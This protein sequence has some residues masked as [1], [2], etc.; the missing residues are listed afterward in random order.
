[1][2]VSGKAP[3]WSKVMIHCMVCVG[4]LL[5]LLW[6][7]CFVAMCILLHRAN[8][9]D[10]RVACAGFWDFMLIS[11]LSPFLIPT[12]YC[13]FSFVM[14][15]GWYPFSGS[16]MLIMGIMSFYVT[17]NA[18]ESSACMEAIRDTTAPIPWLVYVGIIKTIVYCAGAISSLCGHVIQNHSDNG[19]AHMFII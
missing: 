19:Y 13:M 1:M 9:M 4:C 8:T 3:N 18:M 16:C 14:W 10:V 15:W 11:M 2:I 5:F 12:I 17:L 6:V 7:A